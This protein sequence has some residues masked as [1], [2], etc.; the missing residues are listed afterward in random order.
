M[1]SI[2]KLRGSQG[3]V[4]TAAGLCS[5]PLIGGIICAA[6]QQLEP[7]AAGLINSRG[8]AAT[9]LNAPLC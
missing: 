6:L 8:A 9:P 1:K 3:E 5:R 7:G 2:E 4:V